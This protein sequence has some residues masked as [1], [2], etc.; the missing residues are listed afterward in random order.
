MNWIVCFCHS[1][2]AAVALAKN[3]VGSQGLA[4]SNHM[5]PRIVLWNQASFCSVRGGFADRDV[6]YTKVL[7]RNYERTSAMLVRS[8][9]HPDDGGGDAV[10]LDA[11]SIPLLV[12][13]SLSTNDPFSP[14]S[15]GLSEV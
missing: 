12:A 14:S 11:R 15:G 1:R 7:F 13:S 10:G 2:S 3:G 5:Y 6:A 9:C 4:N 8:S